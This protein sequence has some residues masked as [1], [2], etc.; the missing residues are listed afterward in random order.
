MGN[1]DSSSSGRKETINYEERE[2]AQIADEQWIEYKDRYV[3]LENR[4]MDNV[5]TYNDQ[6]NYES[7]VGM[8]HNQYRQSA[9]P[10]TGFIQKGIAS[11]H[12]S[13]L[14]D[15]AIDDARGMAS[16]GNIA[17]QGVTDRYLKGIE[18]VIRVGQGQETNT[19]N[20]LSEIA[21][22]SVE[23]DIAKRKNKWKASNSAISIGGLAAGAVAGATAGGL[24]S[25]DK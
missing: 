24:F 7:A 22:D 1:G 5:A 20:S 21:T 23:A 15:N 8:S 18:N 6:D 3:P 12:Y 10:N 9:G 25:K 16:A 13:G 4:W 19:L 17:S 2:L 14:S 11:G